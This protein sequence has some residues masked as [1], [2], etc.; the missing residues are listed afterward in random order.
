MKTANTVITAMA[1]I[2]W[3]NAPAVATD[4]TFN[5]TSGNWGTPGNWS[6]AGI[7]QDGDTATI[8]GGKTC[9]V[10]D[11]DRAATSFQVGNFGTLKIVGHSLTI[12]ADSSFVD[13]GALIF[14]TDGGNDGELVI[15]AN[16]SISG[17]TSNI[18]AVDSN[19]G[20][21]RTTGD[22]TLTIDGEINSG[23]I[24]WGSF[25]VRVNLVLNGGQ[26]VVESGEVLNLGFQGASA[27]S[28]TIQGAGGQVDMGGGVLHVGVVE[29]LG[30]ADLIDWNAYAGGLIE[31][32][33]VCTDC[34]CF[35]G[36]IVVAGGELE[37]NADL[38]T[39][40]GLTFIGSTIEVADGVSAAF[41][42]NCGS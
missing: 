14:E 24:L 12:T 22:Y 27:A 29:F 36:E 35:R 1:V 18:Y 37:V 34:S 26:F 39:P 9:R 38:C 13:K 8:P 15:G 5:P 25:D 32:S 4:Y 33:S 11:D 23:P 3:T 42:S 28:I 30:G 31:I 20:V 7:P 6:P 10:E 21:I 41:A 16:L 2:A 40:E 19:R 17:D